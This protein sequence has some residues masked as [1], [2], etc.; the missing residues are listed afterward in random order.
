[1]NR[2]VVAGGGLAGI[3]TARGLRKLGYAGELT[4]VGA[5]RHRSY[6]RPP[7]SKEFLAGT[8]DVA[9]ISL[10]LPGEDLGLRWRLGVAAVSLGPTREVGLSDGSRLPA[11]GVVV[12]TGAVPRWLPAGRQLPAGVH[13]LRTLEDSTALRADLRAGGRLAV[14]GAG[15]IG[16]EVASTASRLGL[17]VDVVEVDPVPLRFALGEQMGA[18]VAALHERNGVRL[19]CGVGVSGLLGTGRVSGVALADGREVTAG[20]VVIGIGVTPA[21]DWL[22]SSGIDVGSDGVRCDA[23]GATS[24]PGVVAVGDCSTWLDPATGRHE[25]IEHWTAAR[26]RGVVAAATLLGVTPPK[27]RHGG[28]PYFWSDQY[29]K[30]IQFAGRIC[31]DVDVEEGSIDAGSFL[32]VYRRDGTPVGV[33][34]MDR[35]RAFVAWRRRLAAPPIGGQATASADAAPGT[36]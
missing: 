6:D 2:I 15:F 1:M 25:R 13:V 36:P 30:R 32:A 9:D 33:L 29:G 35:P 11:D 27:P 34:G 16:A 19:H 3:S 28:L 18:A 17:R 21:T 26:D 20:T 22:R 14:V 7:L 12:A 24:L 10:E 5:E 23:A 4:I 8:V 31:P